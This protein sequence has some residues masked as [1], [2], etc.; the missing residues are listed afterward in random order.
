MQIK[1]GRCVFMTQL[2]KAQN[3]GEKRW[4]KLFLNVVV[5]QGNV[6][7]TDQSSPP[8]LKYRGLL[9]QQ[10]IYLCVLKFT[11]ICTVDS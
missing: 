2:N 10:H 9:S 7:R 3:A 11:C 5:L 8:P 1:Y 6:L 4:D